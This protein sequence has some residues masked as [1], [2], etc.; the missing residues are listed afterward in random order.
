MAVVVVGATSIFSQISATHSLFNANDRIAIE[1]WKNTYYK[2][3]TPTGKQILLSSCQSNREMLEACKKALID[4]DGM[5]QMSKHAFERVIKLWTAGGEL[6]KDQS[7][8]EVIDVVRALNA[9]NQ[10]RLDWL[11]KV[12]LQ[13]QQHEPGFL[14]RILVRFSQKGK[15]KLYRELNTLFKWSK[16]IVEQFVYFEN[17]LLKAF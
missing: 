1:T 2:P 14:E 3:L 4:S 17:E 6:I 13:Y 8:T 11:K 10:L 16:E 12:V 5:N 7:A 15:F 9:L